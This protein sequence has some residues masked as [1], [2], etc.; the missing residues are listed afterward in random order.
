M[1]RKTAGVLRILCPMTSVSRSTTTKQLDG[2]QGNAV[3]TGFLT[4][5]ASEVNGRTIKKTTSS[6]NGI[7]RIHGRYG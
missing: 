1:R 4:F 3:R 6:Q 5:P 7:V 2:A